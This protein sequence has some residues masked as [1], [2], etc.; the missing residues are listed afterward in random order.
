MLVSEAEAGSGRSTPETVVEPLKQTR[1]RCANHRRKAT[2]I[3]LAQTSAVPR[4]NSQLKPR[5]QPGSN[6]QLLT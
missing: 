1:L 6:K 5:K 2:L 4:V 3:Q